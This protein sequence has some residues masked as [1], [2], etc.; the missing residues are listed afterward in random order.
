MR[1]KINMTDT[2]KNLISALAITAALGGNMF[3]EF[4]VVP[5][6]TCQYKRLG[7]ETICEKYTRRIP[8][9]VKEN[10]RCKFYQ[11]KVKVE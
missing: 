11:E 10:K 9:A 7:L 2:D 5:C 1:W 6:K 4:K 3:K 8:S